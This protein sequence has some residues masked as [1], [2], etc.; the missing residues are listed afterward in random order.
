MQHLKR[1]NLFQKNNYFYS[2]LLCFM[3]TSMG[4]SYSVKI[5]L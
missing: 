2:S 5:E 1:K 3:I 4:Y